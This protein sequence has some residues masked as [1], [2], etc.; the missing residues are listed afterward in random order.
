MGIPLLLKSPL[1]TENEEGGEKGN[2]K[3]KLWNMG[4]RKV[5]KIV[6]EN[7]ILSHFVDK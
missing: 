2:T 3:N 4:E 7:P 5:N 1:I 6:I